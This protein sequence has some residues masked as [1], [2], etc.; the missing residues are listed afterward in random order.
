M[1]DQLNLTIEEFT[2]DSRVLNLSIA[3][4][5]KTILEMMGYCDLAALWDDFTP[6][7]IGLVSYAGGSCY[8]EIYQ[9]RGAEEYVLTFYA[10]ALV[11]Q[12][13]DE[14][15]KDLEERLYNDWYVPEVSD[16]PT[17]PVEE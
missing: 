11:M 7:L 13:A 9:N 17:L 6:D 5:R 15:L 10:K 1:K 8:I 3:S 14:N 2:K 4:E 12:Y 16:L